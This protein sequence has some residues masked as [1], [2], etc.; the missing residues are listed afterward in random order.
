MQVEYYNLH[1]TLNFTK[2]GNGTWSINA[3]PEYDVKMV[4]EYEDVFSNI[5]DLTDNGNGTWTL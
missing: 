1:E 4:V 5:I 3:M 2:N